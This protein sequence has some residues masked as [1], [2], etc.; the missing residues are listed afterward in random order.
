MYTR[1]VVSLVFLYFA[2]SFW[3]VTVKRNRVFSSHLYCYHAY[4]FIQYIQNHLKFW[5]P[6][7]DRKRLWTGEYFLT[8]VPVRCNGT[9]WWQFANSLSDKF[10]EVNVPLFE[11]GHQRF[12]HGIFK[13][14]NISALL[15]SESVYIVD[16]CSWARL[17]PY[18]SRLW[19]TARINS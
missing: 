19:E 11:Q 1:E 7:D 16:F 18:Y 9:F 8:A 17:I 12:N 14:Q 5:L 13:P 4:R 3:D 6:F 2:R 10:K 15:Q